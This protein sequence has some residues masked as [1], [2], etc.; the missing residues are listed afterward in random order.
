M[1]MRLGSVV[2]T[3]RGR[4]V[5]VDHCQGEWL[6]RLDRGTPLD[7]SHGQWYPHHVVV[8]TG[9]FRPDAMVWF[10]QRMVPAG[11]ILHIPSPLSY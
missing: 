6:V 9:G 2:F 10:A 7:T 3:P 1:N 8:A 11:E 5:L 4:G